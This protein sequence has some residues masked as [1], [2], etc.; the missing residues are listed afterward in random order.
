MADDITVYAYGVQLAQAQIAAIPNM[1]ALRQQF[2]MLQA[3]VDQSC[4]FKAH[5]RVR[6]SP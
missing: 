5:R 2:E 4:E 6:T 3:K 1:P